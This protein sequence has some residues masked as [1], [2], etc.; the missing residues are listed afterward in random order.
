VALL[1]PGARVFLF[2]HAFGNHCAVRTYKE[3]TDGENS[4][5]FFR[6]MSETVCEA[7]YGDLRN[8]LCLACSLP[9]DTCPRFVTVSSGAFAPDSFIFPHCTKFRSRC[10]VYAGNLSVRRTLRCLISNHYFSARF[11]ATTDVAR[12]LAHPLSV[13]VA[14][15]FREPVYLYV[16]SRSSQIHATHRIP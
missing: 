14:S 2:C 4:L 10:G 6:G 1:P 9:D 11:A 13:V 3:E 15:F 12:E 7:W 8:A 5:H 16:G